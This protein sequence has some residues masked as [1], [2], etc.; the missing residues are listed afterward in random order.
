MSNDRI[1]LA[2]KRK[3]EGVRC[4]KNN[5]DFSNLITSVVLDSLCQIPLRDVKLKITTINRLYNHFD[6]SNQFSQ[7]KL[8]F[9][10][11]G[12]WQTN[13]FDNCDELYTE[14]FDFFVGDRP[15]IQTFDT[16]NLNEKIFN[17]NCKNGAHE[18]TEQHLRALTTK[19]TDRVFCW[20]KR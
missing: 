11:R 5:K 19:L 14:I 8:N 15:K 20:K 9:F 4:K 2:Y 6:Y 1:K 3:N 13:T 18:Y 17:R 16:K 7:Q 10:S 12:K